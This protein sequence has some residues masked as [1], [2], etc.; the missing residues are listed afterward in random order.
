MDTVFKKLPGALLPW[1]GENRR[2]LPW[3]RDREPYHVWLSEIMLQQTRVEAVKGYYARFL[4]ALPTVEAL[5][6]CDDEKLT[7]LWE[8]LGYY[9]RVRNLKKAAGVIME[10]YG[11]E[12][13]GEY[14][15]VL[16]L[17]GIGEYTAGAICS[18]CFDQRTAAVD[19][20]VLRVVS[21]LTDDATPIDDPVC[22]K[23][24]KARLEAVYP[25]QAGDFTQALMELGATVCGPNRK[26]DCGSCPCRDFCLGHLR[27]TCEMLPVKTPK[28]QKRREERTVFLLSCGD[29][30]ALCKRPERGLLA[31]LWQFPDTTGAMDLREALE[32]VRHLGMEPREIYRK[33]E[34][35]HIFTHIQW[36]MTGYYLE[37]AQ[38][39]GQFRWLTAEEVDR[40]AALP[41]AYRQFWET[42]LEEENHGLSDGGL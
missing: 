16:A 7:K 9:S 41:T 39:A 25:A 36:D 17:P 21:R 29:R 10:K 26:P 2:E 5:A 22:K 4:E 33:L 32:H 28:K 38:P 6:A 11:G 8:G 42:R 23:Q 30:Y 35:K 40:E 19:G 15:A 34:K 12:F 18:I 1:Y 20:N 37:I 31:G 13:P 24:V 3:R 27:G 14:S